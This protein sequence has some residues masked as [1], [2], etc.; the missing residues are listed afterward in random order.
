MGCDLL[1]AIGAFPG[2]CR[3]P[4]ILYFRMIAGQN[5]ATGSGRNQEQNPKVENSLTKELLAAKK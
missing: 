2:E 5:I 1:A 4:S 3:R